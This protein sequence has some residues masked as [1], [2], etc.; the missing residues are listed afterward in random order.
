M[1]GSHEHGHATRTTSRTRLAIAF[2]VAVAVF[3]LQLIGGLVANSLA[4]LADAAHVA[5]DAGGVG[6]ALFAATMALRPATSGRTY[7]WLRLEVLTAAINA[8]LRL[9]VGGW[10]LLEAVNRLRDPG[11]VQTTTMLI[12]ATIG[13]AANG[14]SLWV[15]AGADRR[16]LN[17]RGAYLEVLADLLGSAAVIAAALIIRITGFDRADSVVAILIATAIVP[18]TLKLLREALDVLLEATPKGVDLDAVRSH[19]LATDGVLD[20]HDLHA[21]TITSGLPVLSAHV[22]IGE[23]DLSAGLGGAV[24]DRISHCL[25][26]HFDVDHCTFQLESAEHQAHERTPC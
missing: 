5:T 26:G 22:V 9:A 17:I 25:A 11:A 4:L 7:G 18:R 24:L 20:V 3:V 15:L 8:A 23:V 19:L 12:V 21:W 10:V 14:V 1:S 6:L 13:M 2:G 16:N